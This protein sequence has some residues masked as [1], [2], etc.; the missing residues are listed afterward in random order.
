MRVMHLVF[1]SVLLT[2]LASS[3]A[4]ASPYPLEN[5]LGDHEAAKLAK[6]RIM[7]SAQLLK[8]GAKSA[9]R[10]KL[11]KATGIDKA[12]LTSMVR[13]CDLLRIKGVGPQMVKLL[14]EA[15]VNTVKLL[16]KQKAAVLA[17][18]LIQANKKAKITQTPPNA[19]QL[20]NWIAQAR[21]LKLVLK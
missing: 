19:E 5:I 1:G 16:Q 10:V 21:K 4:L 17:R 14:A 12:R 7:T 11:A 8:R 9:A 15:K 6:Q 20:K 18:Q 3:A 13:M 2:A